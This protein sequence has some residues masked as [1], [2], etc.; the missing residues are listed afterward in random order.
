MERYAKFQGSW[1]PD[2]PQLLEGMIDYGKREGTSR[3][4]VLPHSGLIF[5]SSHIKQ[6]FSTLSSS[7]RKLII[8]SPSH[9]F[10]LEPDMIVSSGFTSSATPLGSI[11]THPLDIGARAD[12]AI[13]AEHG[14]EMFLP[15]IAH[16]GTLSVSYILLSS[17]SSKESIRKTAERILS[18][19]DDETGIIA[20][21]DF[22]HYGPSYSYM[23]YGRD[24][25]GKAVDADMEIAR[26]LASGNAE[27]AWEKGRNGTICGIAPASVASCIAGMLN[28][29][30][31]I[32]KRS[33][34]ADTTGDRNEFVSYCTIL[35]RDR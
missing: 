19:A 22:T 1:Y 7:I 3:I 29:E 33:T 28:L 32:G 16:E 5:S 23:P 11:A 20:S 12:S 14:I 10:Y 25:Y 2:D 8:I 26:L 24:G 4:A 21:S 18:L 35:W 9:Y 13:Q 34:S 27:K 15:F 30:G 17:L 31:S 6:Y